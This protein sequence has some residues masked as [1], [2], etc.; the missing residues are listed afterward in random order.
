MISCSALLRVERAR[1]TQREPGWGG[2]G[3]G[4]LTAT[5]RCSPTFLLFFAGTFPATDKEVSREPAAQQFT[6]RSCQEMITSS[7]GVPC[8][9]PPRSWQLL[10]T[11]AFFHHFFFFA[12]LVCVFSDK[13]IDL[14]DAVS[15]S[16]VV[17]VLSSQDCDGSIAGGRRGARCHWRGLAWTAWG[18]KREV[19]VCPLS[20]TVLLCVLLQLIKTQRSDDVLSSTKTTHLWNPWQFVTPNV[21]SF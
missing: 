7:S 3:G 2:V 18:K 11:W 4:G 17:V 16:H 10:A 20:S 5:Q 12:T 6:L 21:G 14:L 9:K 1:N 13:S 15:V 19:S 8:G